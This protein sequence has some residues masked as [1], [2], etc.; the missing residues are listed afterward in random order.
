MVEVAGMPIPLADV[1]AAVLQLSPEV[2]PPAPCKSA[3]QPVGETPSSACLAGHE[4]S[5]LRP[6]RRG[7]VWGFKQKVLPEP[8]AAQEAAWHQASQLPLQRRYLLHQTS[9]P[10]QEGIWAAD[11]PALETGLTA[12]EPPQQPQLLRAAVRL[13]TDA[14]LDCGPFEVRTEPRSRASQSGGPS[15]RSS[16]GGGPS[17]RGSQAGGHVKRTVRLMPAVVAAFN[18]KYPC[19]AQE[20]AESPLGSGSMR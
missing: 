12:T 11:R 3:S 5:S 4:R 15:R 19:W 2:P 14:S 7:S 1:A 9:A 16:Q 18:R 6:W 20:L 8:A 13:L 17:H 10:A